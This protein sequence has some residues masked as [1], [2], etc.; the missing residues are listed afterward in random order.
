MPSYVVTGRNVE[1]L[2]DGDPFRPS[3]A[4]VVM[5]V[6]SS[7][8]GDGAAVVHTGIDGDEAERFLTEMQRRGEI[9]SWR[10]EYYGYTGLGL[11]YPTGEEGTIREHFPTVGVPKDTLM[12]ITLG[13]ADT[14]TPPIA[15]Q[16]GPLSEYEIQ[17]LDS[18]VDEVGHSTAV[19]SCTFAKRL[20]FAQALP[21]GT[22]SESTV[23]NAIKALA[24][25]GAR[26]INL[27]LGWP[28][29]SPP[30]SEIIGAAVRYAQSKGALCGAAAGNSGWTAGYGSPQAEA[31]FVW[32]A[33]TLDG[34]APA[35][36]TSGGSNWEIETA[37]TPGKDVGVA[38][39]DGGYGLADGTSFAA[40]LGNSLACAMYEHN[41]WSKETTVGYI[42]AHMQAYSPP[43]LRGL[44][45]VEERDLG[46]GEEPMPENP[47]D[48]YQA[49]WDICDEIWRL[50][51][52][53]QK[54]AEHGNLWAG[55]NALGPVKEYARQIQAKLP[56][57]QTEPP[58]PPEPVPD[59]VWA[60]LVSGAQGLAGAK[61]WYTGPNANGIDIFVRR[62]TI[63]RA[64]FAGT[65]KFEQVPGGPM[66]IGQLTLTHSDG[67][68]VRYRHVAVS[69]QQLAVFGFKFLVGPD[70]KLPEDQYVNQGQALSKVLVNDPSMDILHW[71]PGYPTPPDGYQH[72]DLSLASHPSR[73]DPTGGAG[74]DVNAYQHIWGK[75]GGIPG[76]QIIPRTPGPQEGLMS[77]T[78][79]WSQS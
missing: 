23:A 74:G 61:K 65:V 24:D 57:D 59:E 3:G 77:R 7:V 38:H 29:K 68:T 28:G 39:L 47:G 10:E 14:G 18:A 1:Y 44:V 4:A 64:P 66:L 43:R 54:E 11:V 25:A 69:Q 27:S 51:D 8:E 76:I 72:L 17:S 32:G 19:A 71:P 20:L 34:K 21:A 35:S 13:I 16:Q 6:M 40:P 58:P 60:T 55:V 30:T 22:G 70:G 52:D 56:K 73:M 48:W 79:E 46:L 41:A 63:V 42:R 9:D 62:G 31:D 53:A 5:R 2:K 36:F 12:D 67:R 33:S 49:I 37:A 78:N 50:G 45:V 26:V 15:A 75:K